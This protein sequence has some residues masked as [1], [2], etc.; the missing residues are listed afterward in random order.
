[1]GHW[2]KLSVAAKAGQRRDHRR[3]AESEVPFEIPEVPEEA[4]NEAGARLR[5]LLT[6][7]FANETPQMLAWLMHQDFSVLVRDAAYDAN[8]VK[9][10][11][12]DD[13]PAI[14]RIRRR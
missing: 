11:T 10:L 13:A 12:P 6:Q 8:L 5:A 1:M 7:H 4:K 14:R 2:N 9:M 3:T